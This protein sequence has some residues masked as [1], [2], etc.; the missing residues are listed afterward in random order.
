MDRRRRAEVVVHSSF[1]RGSR[2]GVLSA[3]PVG[4]RPLVSRSRI[5]LLV[6]LMA[7][8]VMPLLF[9]RPPAKKAADNAQPPGAAPPTA[10]TAADSDLPPRPHP[11]AVVQAPRISRQWLT[12]G[13]G[14]P[15][16][17]Y[18]ML[19]TLDNLGGT[20]RRI[21]LNSRFDD[22][23]LRYRDIDNRHGYLGFL[24]L[25]DEP[26][27]GCRIR[28]VGAG[29]PAAHAV[30][31][32]GQATGLRRDDVIKEL[33]GEP[34]VNADD[35]EA[36]LRRRRPGDQVRLTIERGD[37]QEDRRAADQDVAAENDD[38][39]AAAPAASASS[40]RLELI[41]T[42]AEVPMQL[43]APA[44]DDQLRETDILRRSFHFTL[45]QKA[46]L[47]QLWPE[48][49]RAMRAAHWEHRVIDDA[50]GSRVEFR[51]TIP[52]ATLQPFGLD[53]PLE[54]IKTYSMPVPG[55]GGDQALNRE[56]H[57]NLEIKIVNHSSQPQQ[58]AYQMIGPSGTPTE[59]WWYQTKVHGRWTAVGRGAGPRDIVVSTNDQNYAFFGGPEIISNYLESPPPPFYVISPSGDE[60]RTVNFIGVDAQYFTVALL[61]R[62][63][64]STPVS[65]YSGWAIPTSAIPETKGRRKLTD[66]SFFLF[67]D[68]IAIPP[69]GD[70]DTAFTQSFEVFA[71][72]K[73]PRLLRQYG[74]QD[75]VTYGWFWFFSKPLV[76]LLHTF[77]YV[78]PYAVG[79][80]LLTA[81]V[82]TLMIPISR[83][84]V[85]NA[86][87]MQRL[88][89]EMKRIA[90]KY[91][92]DIQKRSEAQRE[93]FRRY[94]YNPFGGCLLIFLQIPIFMGLYRGLAVDVA[95]RDQPLIH[96]LGWCSNLAAP[97]QLFQW[98]SWM[99]SFLGDETG[100][101][102]PYFNLLPVLT[103][104]LFL[105]QQK[106][107]MPPP[108]DEQQRMMHRVMNFMM[109]FMGFLFFKVPSGLC[110]YFITSSLW[111]I[112][113]RKLLPK[114]QLPDSLDLPPANKP[115]KKSPAAAPSPP[116]VPLSNPKQVEERRLR[117][118]D[119]QRRLRE[120]Q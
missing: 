98:S 113:E 106:M 112:A 13:S 26:G 109:L 87:M 62:T 24:E 41:T 16:S 40:E 114:P 65:Y 119:R 103:I 73:E 68:A 61:P 107:F 47:G 60:Q 118:R 78:V 29:T 8:V 77:H 117:D 48:L 3:V 100:F 104:V 105:V 42:L 69:A 11:T 58:I 82:R 5:I 67:S 99:P 93:L 50:A 86:Q 45:H 4:P 28:V 111:G 7:I 43:I 76:W 30:A 6:A 21:E 89:P 23:R 71:G 75:C 46:G 22:G 59:G 17:P 49:D 2:A 102:G 110:I 54:V 57:F 95:L 9:P 31:T 90:E 38:A 12:I 19:V 44:P 18:R 108:T 96:G 79:I 35:F 97:D 55:S 85:L 88:Q 37:S 56:F 15:T 10:R 34:I 94:K 91:K 32:T 120:R 116:A 72:P 64:E 115:V 36:A 51:F 14:D 20:V 63:S 92:D 1:H 27:G 101:L 81:I 74:L 83:K 70:S 39:G 25:T 84:A 33:D 66:L 52:A 53:G 80:V